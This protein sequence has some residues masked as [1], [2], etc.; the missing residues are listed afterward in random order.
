MAEAEGERCLQV[1]VQR[2]TGLRAADAD[3]S[4]DPYVKLHYTDA[5]S[6][7]KFA[8]TKVK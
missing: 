1:T 6:R 8:Q 5:G 7:I 4:S 3:G 2:A